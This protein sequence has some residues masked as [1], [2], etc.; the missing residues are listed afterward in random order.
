[1]TGL[2]APEDHVLGSM[3][4]IQGDQQHIHIRE[5]SR[6]GMECNNLLN[7]NLDTFAIFFINDFDNLSVGTGAQNLG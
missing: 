3:P 4:G 1:M 7:I 2:G 5:E 6:V